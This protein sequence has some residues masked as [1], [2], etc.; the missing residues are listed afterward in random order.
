M[1]PP[2][3]TTPDMVV[4]WRRH[5]CLPRPHSWGRL[6]RDPQRVSAR[7]RRRQTESL[8]HAAHSQASLGYLGQRG[9]E[10]PRTVQRFGT[11]QRNAAL[12]G[13]IAENHIDIV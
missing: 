5:S 7:V 10:L 6:V 3:M 9:G 1:P 4:A 2:M 11:E 13:V 12:G 8:R